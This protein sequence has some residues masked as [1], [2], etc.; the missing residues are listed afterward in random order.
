MSIKNNNENYRVDNFIYSV[1]SHSI[2]FVLLS[3]IQPLLLLLFI[4]ITRTYWLILYN[5]IVNS[6]YCFITLLKKNGI[7]L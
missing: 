5:L 4:D 2:L 1:L 6:R 3:F 7:K